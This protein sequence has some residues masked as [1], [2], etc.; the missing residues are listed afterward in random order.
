MFNGVT[1]HTIGILLKNEI[2]S[3]FKSCHKIANLLQLVKD[4]RDKLLV[5]IHQMCEHGKSYIRK[6][7]WSEKTNIKEHEQ[8]FLFR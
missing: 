1:E 8:Y 5:K 3:I 7:G 4:K 2:T 6:T